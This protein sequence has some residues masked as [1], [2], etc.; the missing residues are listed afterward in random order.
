[1]GPLLAQIDANACF[2][3]DA[4]HWPSDGPTLT[5]WIFSAPCS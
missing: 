1:M 2:R 3:I 5:G 4:F